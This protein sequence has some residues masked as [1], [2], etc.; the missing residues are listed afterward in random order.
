MREHHTITKQAKLSTIHHI[1][2][3]AAAALG[4]DGAAPRPER[5]GSGDAS[6][7]DDSAATGAA[8]A[9]PKLRLRLKH[10]GPRDWLLLLDDPP[11]W[12]GLSKVGPGRVAFTGGAACPPVR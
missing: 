4:S 12:Q 5:D 2:M 9:V 3:Q 7:S 1:R 6:T 11:Q 8:A 10:P